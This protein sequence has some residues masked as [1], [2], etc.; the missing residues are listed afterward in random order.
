[1]PQNIFK[2]FDGRNNFWQWDTSQKLIVLDDTITEVH[3]SNRDMTYAIAKP[4]YERDGKRLC[5]IPDTILQIPRNL[6]AY[7]TDGNGTKKSVMFAVTKRQI[8]TGYVV[9]ETERFYEI[10]DRL[11]IL[12][13]VLAD[14]KENGTDG[15]IPDFLST[16]EATAWAKENDKTNV[17]VAIKI[18]DKWIAHMVED[19]YSVTSICDLKGEMVAIHVM[20]GGNAAGV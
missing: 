20:D 15:I 17:I 19:D 10:N 12:E 2:I 16:A 18:K 14:V 9:D 6:I 13:T 8:P 4:V 1:M 11:A 7:A 3:F 5:N